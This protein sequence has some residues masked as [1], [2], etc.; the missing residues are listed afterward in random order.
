[1]EDQYKVTIAPTKYS[2]RINWFTC[3]KFL[4]SLPIWPIALAVNIFG[5]L[6]GTG[7]ILYSSSD[8]KECWAR[9][10]DDCY[11]DA[12]IK[13]NYKFITKEKIQ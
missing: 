9:L 4:L 3:F 7:C 5:Y 1:M 6:I 12:L 10:R 2:Y 8:W 13:W 11:G